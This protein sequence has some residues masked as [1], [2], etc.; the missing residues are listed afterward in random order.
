MTTSFPIPRSRYT[1]DVSGLDPLLAKVMY[2]SK[3]REQTIEAMRIM[4][5]ESRICGP[6][7]NLEFL[8]N[9]LADERFVA[10]NTL[11]KFLD[12]FEFRP[13]AIDV[14]SGG[15]YT[16]IEDWPGR[17]TLGRGFCHSGPMDPLAFRIANALVGNPVETEALEITLSGPDLRFLG[18]A[19]VSLCGAAISATLDGKPVAMWSRLRIA[20]GQRLTIGKVTGGG[21]RTYLAVYGGFL[22]VAAWFGSKSTSPMVG[23]GGYQGRQLAAG[24]LLSISTDPPIDQ[25]DIALPESL[26]PTYPNNWELLSMPGPF[27]VGYITEEGMDMIFKTEW[28]VSHN[29]ARGG[30]RLIGPKPKFARSDGG[31]GGAHPSNLIEYGYGIGAINW[32]GD[33]P[34]IFPV[35]CPDLG[36]FISSHTIVKG[37]LWKMGQLKAGDIVKFRAVSLEDAILSRR[38]TERFADAVIAASRKAGDFS[39]IAPLSGSLPPELKGKN[40]GTGL[41]HQIQEQGNKPL[42]SYRQVRLTVTIIIWFALTHN[43]ERRRLYPDRLRP[44]SL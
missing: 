26:I 17:P 43:S 25:G 37:D 13:S 4:L 38:E 34:V 31:E 8:A 35:D 20:A 6:P 11:T 32:T 41:V 16:L 40:M 14:L 39:G 21:C 19:M 5:R 23:V 28:K 7:T 12:T 9:I 3:S 33:D 27:D 2:H 1:H 18:P 29:A 42:V 24:D 30:I 36:G 10:G 44:W 22:N 15:A